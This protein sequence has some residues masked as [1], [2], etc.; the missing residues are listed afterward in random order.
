[1]GDTLAL[2]YHAVSDRWPAGFAVPAARIEAAG[3][4]AA[5]PWLRRRHVQGGD[6]R[7][8]GDA[9]LDRDLRR[10]L[11]VGLR[12]GATRARV[13]RRP[14]DR[15]RPHRT[16]RHR[17]T[18]G[19]ARNRPVARL[20]SRGRADADVVERAR[21]AQR[22]RLGARVPYEDPPASADPRR[23]FDAGGARGLPRRP[24]GAHRRSLRVDR[25][26]LRR[27]RR[28]RRRGVAAGRFQR[29][30]RARGT[31]SQARRDAL[32]TGRR[33]RQGRRRTLPDQSLPGDAPGSRDPAVEGP[34]VLRRRR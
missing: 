4:D 26:P 13:A 30:R 23:R 18:D 10:R 5:R 31:G 19:L 22:A 24:R 3:Q 12:R 28:G 25:L 15:L 33:L 16:D 8:A 14:G 32:A 17:A 20:P 21:R 29:R 2:C 9:N 34:I 1:M 27:L 7:A 11:P 6:L